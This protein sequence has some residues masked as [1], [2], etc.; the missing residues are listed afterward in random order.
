MMVDPTTPTSRPR[1]SSEPLPPY[2]YVPGSGTPHPVSDPRGH[3]YGVIHAAP[4]PLDPESWQASPAY[5]YAV[6]LF[7]HGF[8][9]E[10]HEAWESLWH[11]AGRRGPVA[12]WLKALIKLAAA[13]VKGFESNP[14][15]VQRH[16]RRALELVA[17]VRSDLP[18]GQLMFAGMSLAHVEGVAKSFRR[19]ARERFESRLPPCQLREWLPLGEV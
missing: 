2:A 9:W 17:E 5:L 19:D 7:N 12:A 11:A 18:A 1:Y 8:Y 10:S 16:A 14:V 3:M 4:E 6:D 15:G 13:A